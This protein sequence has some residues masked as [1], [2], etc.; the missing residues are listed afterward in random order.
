MS[1]QGRIGGMV[2]TDRPIRRLDIADLP[3]CLR[4]AENRGWQAEEHKW[5]ML[6]A[7]GHGYGIDDPAGGLAGVVVCTRYGP[8]L[9]AIGM[10]L[11]AAQHERR[12]IGAHLMR[13]A[14]THAEAATVWL[15]ATEFGRPL[16]EKLGFRAIDEC[17]QY[18][19][20]L[21]GARPGRSRPVTTADLPGILAM[22]AEVF[23]ADRAA[24]LH[25]LPAFGEAFRL[26]DGPDGLVGFGAA[27]RNVDTTVLGP[28]IAPDV[29]VARALLTDLAAHVTGPVRLDLVHSRPS[30]LAWARAHGLRPASTTTVMIHGGELPGDRD[31]LFNPLMVAMG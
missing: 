6:F 4:L 16:Y 20:E 1:T 30:Q 8:K 26:V 10:M 31:R 18:I 23:G 7:A 15:T 12:G 29:D 13:H 21:H 11:V 3:D 25:Q 9:A 14:L 17:A 27:W 22:D 19:G 2:W 28:V 5:R 24:V